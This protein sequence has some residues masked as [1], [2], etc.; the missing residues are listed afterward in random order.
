MNRIDELAAE[1]ETGIPVSNSPVNVVKGRGITA[2][3]AVKELVYAY[4]MWISPKFQLKV[5][6]AGR[7]ENYGKPRQ[8]ALMLVE[9]GVS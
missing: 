1:L 8:M 5:I 6:R 4:A 9:G 3:C 2:T 7:V